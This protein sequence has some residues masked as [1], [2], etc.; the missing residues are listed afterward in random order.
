MRGRNQTTSLID[1]VSRGNEE[2]ALTP[3]N[4]SRFTAGR[5][6]CLDGRG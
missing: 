5:R 6:F 2:W 1:L 3:E 4:F